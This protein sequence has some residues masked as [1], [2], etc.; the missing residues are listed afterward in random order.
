[1][2]L[3]LTQS[4]TKSTFLSS[5]AF[6]SLH[7]DSSFNFHSASNFKSH[8]A[9][10]LA[11]PSLPPHLHL[12]LLPWPGDGKEY[13]A[14]PD[15]YL[16]RAAS[17]VPPFTAIPPISVQASGLRLL[18]RSRALSAFKPR[19]PTDKGILNPCSSSGGGLTSCKHAQVRYM[20]SSMQPNALNL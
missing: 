2:D 9:T 16:A 12:H 1:M 8:R 20:W 7:N 19:G 17:L 4:K 6:N 5:G 18:N 14:H 13:P 3:L 11:T 10:M 15:R